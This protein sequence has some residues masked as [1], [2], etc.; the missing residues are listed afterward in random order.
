[1][2]AE[3]IDVA[4]VAQQIVVRAGRIRGTPTSVR[5]AYSSD[6]GQSWR[7]FASEPADGHGAGT[8]AV[9]AD[10]GIVLWM[11]SQAEA[12]WSTTDHGVHWTRAAGVPASSRV[13]ADRVD[14]K[15]FYAWSPTE[16][17]LYVS[18]DGGRVFAALAGTFAAALNGDT[19]DAFATP[20]AAGDLW[21]AS[22]AHGLIHGDSDGRWIGRAAHI[23][24]ADALGFG[25]PASGSITPTLFVAGKRDGKR[26]LYRSTDNGASWVRI[27]DDAH[28]FGRIGH[29]TGDP[30][31]FG[32]VYV[33]T[34][35][36]GI[37]YGDEQH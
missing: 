21:F 4:G 27:N 10:G 30:R 35:G 23:D 26:G 16:S 3:S 9:A 20:G 36:R 5:A 31:V 24:V 37:F 1:M 22:S 14:P 2:N 18:H 8:I 12:A 33:A 15:R 19:G 32:R 29:V 7:A 13:F 25:K 11:P 6:S 28:Q 34:G 17:R